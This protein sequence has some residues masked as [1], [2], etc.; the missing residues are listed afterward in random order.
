M[1]ITKIFSGVLAVVCTV[2]V[3]CRVMCFVYP[4][5]YGAEVK[6]YAAMY[7]VDEEMIF[8]VIKAESNFESDAVSKKGAVGLMQVMED[9]ARWIAERTGI[10]KFS[11][12]D[13]DSADKNIKIGAWYLSYLLELYDDDVKCALAAYNAG[14]ANVNGWLDNATVLENIPFP[15]TEKYVKK[16]QRFIKIYQF[17]Y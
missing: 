8:S 10:D 4:K 2:V 9:T 3:V 15:E 13:L 6:K 7:D 11:A 12:Q 17:L 16:T 5:K 1:K 14:P